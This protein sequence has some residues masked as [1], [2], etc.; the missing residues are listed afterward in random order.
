VAGTRET[1]RTHL[2]SA[3][4]FEID[5]VL[6]TVCA[7][8]SIAEKWLPALPGADHLAS[9]PRPCLDGETRHRVPRRRS[10]IRRMTARV[11]RQH[12]CGLTCLGCQPGDRRWYSRR[13]LAEA[14]LSSRVS[15]RSEGRG[16]TE[17]WTP[18]IRLESR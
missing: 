13:G 1:R 18:L 6:R 12:L 8:F 9:S 5:A 4:Q 10:G 7:S 11:G 15:Y 3:P 17:T 2:P 14:L 16:R